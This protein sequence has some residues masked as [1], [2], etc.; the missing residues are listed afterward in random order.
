MF[1]G[2]AKAPEKRTLVAWGKEKLR[3]SFTFK[4]AE[5]VWREKHAKE[6]QEMIAINSSL[7]DEDRGKAM[8]KLEKD[9]ATAAKIKVVGNYGA[10]ALVTGTI[11]YGGLLVGNETVRKWTGE[12]PFVGKGLE[13]FGQG[14]ADFLT[15]IGERMRNVRKK[16]PIADP[17]KKLSSGENKSRAEQFPIPN[18]FTV[19]MNADKDEIEELIAGFDRLDKQFNVK[20][21]LPKGL[22]FSFGSHDLNNQQ[23]EAIANAVVT[24]ALNADGQWQPLFIKS[25]TDGSVA[26]IDKDIALKPGWWR[27]GFAV[28]TDKKM[29]DIVDLGKGI[30]A[31]VITEKF[32]EYLKKIAG[33]RS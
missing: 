12:V 11:T 1:T 19:M 5:E 4:G 15:R 20:N 30:G 26:W 14:G 27:K 31:F 8:E 3:K 2:M 25:Y 13:A 29:G 33:E 7:S 9:I 28:F 23:A 10:A 22:N 16:T 32:G 18:M 6:I 21:I 17:E 24:R